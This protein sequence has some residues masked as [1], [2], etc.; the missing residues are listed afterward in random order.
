MLDVFIIEKIRRED[1]HRDS[2]KLPLRIEISQERPDEQAVQTEQ[3]EEGE[4]GIAIIDFS[5]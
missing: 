2:D 3:E 4:R 1:A 5:V